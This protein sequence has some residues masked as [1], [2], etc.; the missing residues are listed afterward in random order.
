MEQVPKNIPDVEQYARLSIYLILFQ[1]S[2]PFSMKKKFILWL[3]IAALDL[4][5]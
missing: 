3:W 4:A 5:C 2:F 1:Y